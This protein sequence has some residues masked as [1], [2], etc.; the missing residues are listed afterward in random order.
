MRRDV[1][2]KERA[3]LLGNGA[4]RPTAVAT[5]PEADHPSDFIWGVA[6]E[7][8]IAAFLNLEARQ[9]YY[10]IDKG[11]IPVRKLGHRTIV[12]SRAQLRKITEV[13]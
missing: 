8:G 9:A 11:L 7:N 4:L 12:A 1:S 2:G 10:L 3:I 6:G 13:K 5:P